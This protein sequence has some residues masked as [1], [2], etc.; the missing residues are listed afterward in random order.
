MKLSPDK[1]QKIAVFRALQLGDLLCT[2]PAFRALRNAYPDAEITLLSLPWASEFVKRFSNYFDRFVHFPGYPDL[3]EQEYN[4]KALADFI[5]KMRDEQFDLLL[6]MQG[7]GTIV[8]NL[9]RQFGATCVAGFYNEESFINSEFFMPYPNYGSEIERH[10]LLMQH[11]GIPSQGTQLEFPLTE[12]DQKDFDDLLLPIFPKK[13]VCIHPGS[14]GAYRQM[15][16][17]YFAALADYCI[18]QEF[19]V[20]ITGT[21]SETDISKE[22]IKCMKHFAIDV[23]G[24]TSLGAVAILIKNAF[25]L[26]SNCTGVSHIAAAMQTPSIVIS[27]DG[28]PERWA[29]LNKELHKVIDWTKNPHFDAALL[30]T[31]TLINNKKIASKNQGQ[32]KDLLLF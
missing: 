32:Q 12:K 29:P 16:P 28:E 27:M 7:N 3:P 21:K 17:Q 14:R 10:L 1:I 31:V 2:V 9:L 19:I 30:E 5:Q 6:Q 22:V 18:E 24:K 25:A 26:I 15:P 20:V 8:N 4:A 23:T 13:Y 11:L